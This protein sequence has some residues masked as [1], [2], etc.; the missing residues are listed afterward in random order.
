MA[1]LVKF[2]SPNPKEETRVG[3]LQTQLK[4]MKAKQNRIVP[5]KSATRAGVSSVETKMLLERIREASRR[6]DDVLSE[7][8]DDVL[9]MVA[10]LTGADEIRRSPGLKA[11]LHRNGDYLTDRHDLLQFAALCGGKVLRER[12]ARKK[13]KS[14]DTLQ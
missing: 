8:C 4:T 1:Q 2:D 12:S 6:H 9:E 10:S 11:I 3:K 5:K 7:I 14:N 13:R